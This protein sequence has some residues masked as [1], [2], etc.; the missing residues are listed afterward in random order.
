MSKPF[1]LVVIHEGFVKESLI[2]GLDGKAI[3]VLDDVSSEIDFV[4]VNFDEDLDQFVEDNT[5]KAG[6]LIDVIRG[7]FPELENMLG[8]EEPSVDKL[9]SVVPKRVACVLARLGDSDFQVIDY[10]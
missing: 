10:D 8:T 3:S 1:V 7:Y 6:A 4:I 5:R 9:F 2:V